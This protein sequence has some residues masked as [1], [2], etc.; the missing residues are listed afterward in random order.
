MTQIADLAFYVFHTPIA[1]PE[2]N[3]VTLWTERKAVLVRMITAT[4]AI[5]LGEAWAP[6]N[7][8]EPLIA[9]VRKAMRV[10]RG[11]DVDQIAQATGASGWIA[12]SLRGALDTAWNDAAAR[13]AGL[14]LA[15]HLH[16]GSTRAF[17]V[18]ASGGLYAATKSNAELAREMADAVRAGFTVV[19]MKVGALAPELDL[20]RIRAVRSAIGD[21][22]LVVDALSRLASNDAP[23]AIA[24][25]ADEG[26][27]AVQAPIALDRIDDAIAL[28]ARA[29]IS[30]WFGEAE[31][32]IARLERLADGPDS[33][34]V[35]INPARIGGMR[36]A[37]ALARRAR[38]N[39]PRATL[40]CHATAVL[41][42]ACFHLAAVA[43]CFMHAEFHRFHTHLQECMP[44][45]MH[46]VRDGMIALSDEPGLG[47]DLPLDDPRL[48]RIAG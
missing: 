35:Q 33:L 18:Y 47:F 30:L 2:G 41:Q 13:E 22:A 28:A 9:I 12:D 11:L 45:A 40:Q 43:E 6:A 37:M 10:C 23:T 24:R 5:G 19:K 20:A 8:I 46:D 44:H 26:V 4:G 14:P 17:H 15:R 32:D 21:A 39:Q 3:G 31:G 34:I 42:A 1:R 36:S 7:A 48:T 38:R 29:P 25:F 27:A 16:S